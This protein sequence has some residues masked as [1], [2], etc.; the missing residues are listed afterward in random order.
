MRW[1]GVVVAGGQVLGVHMHVCV[2]RFVSTC[3]DPPRTGRQ[4]CERVGARLT[5]H[6]LIVTTSDVARLNSPP[7]PQKKHVPRYNRYVTNATTTMSRSA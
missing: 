3:L 4:M 6:L 5:F 7:S 1:G 2:A